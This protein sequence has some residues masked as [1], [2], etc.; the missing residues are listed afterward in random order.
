MLNFMLC[1]FYHH[2]VFKK[3]QLVT[4]GS[5]VYY[6]ARINPKQE[7]GRKWQYAVFERKHYD[8]FSILN[9]FQ[10]LRFSE[11]NNYFLAEDFCLHLYILY[12]HCTLN[13]RLKLYSI[14][15]NN[16]YFEP[17]YCLFYN[18]SSCFLALWVWGFCLASFAIIEHIFCF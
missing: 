18:K 2:F 11:F 10:C 1:G 17:K 7:N 6:K 16:R 13:E 12:K 5:E 8:S 4:I 3:S 9:S 15:C 14:S